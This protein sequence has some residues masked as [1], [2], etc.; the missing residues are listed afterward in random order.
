LQAQMFPLQQALRGRKAGGGGGEAA[1]GKVWEMGRTRGITFGTQG[2]CQLKSGCARARRGGEKGGLRNDTRFC[3]GVFRAHFRGHG[4]EGRRRP[5]CFEDGLA[6]KR[7]AAYHHIIVRGVH[8]FCC[9]ALH[10][11]ARTCST[12]TH[13]RLRVTVTHPVCHHHLQVMYTV[14]GKQLNMR[15]S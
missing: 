1:R 15:A 14:V 11:P 5:G 13:A 7:Q 12:R 6:R 10:P 2:M 9:R 8:A 4:R 3:A